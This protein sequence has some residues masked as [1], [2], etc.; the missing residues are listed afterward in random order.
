MMMMMLVP[1]VLM[2]VVTKRRVSVMA[3]GMKTTSR[4]DHHHVFWCCPR[5]G[6]VSRTAIAM[7]GTVA[8]DAANAAVCCYEV[9]NAWY[10]KA[11]AR[12]TVTITGCIIVIVIVIITA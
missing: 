1:L 11:Q 8:T 2:M 3:M 5:T 9:W 12:V 7:A 10:V 4:V 6:T